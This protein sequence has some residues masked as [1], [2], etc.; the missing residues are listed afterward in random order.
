MSLQLGDG[1]LL[2]QLTKKN[3]IYNFR[4]NDIKNGGEGAPLTPIYHKILLK[5]IKYNLPAGILN[6]GG[7][8]NFTLINDY[9]NDKI[10]SR[11][12][13]PGNCLIDE[14]IQSNTNDFFD[15]EGK[16]SFRGKTNEVLL[17]SAL[18]SYENIQSNNK[19]KTYDIS[20]FNIAFARGL[21]IEDGAATLGEYTSRIIV[22][23]LNSFL[24]EYKISN[25]TILVCG[26]GRKNKYLIDRINSN[27]YNKFKLTNIDDYKI[28]GDFIESQAF[29]YLAIRSYLK[30]PF[31]FPG[32]TGCDKP[33]SGGDFIKY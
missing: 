15:N 10:Y 27:A 16:I 6:I 9:S 2:S 11:D 28:N 8:C 3:I 32:T 4:S 20:D 12:I 17:E 21:S 7:I 23:S 26:G 30:L 24:D 33:I 14:W 29:A 31:T 13:G 1:N 18:E 5:K 22:S 19:Y 25:I